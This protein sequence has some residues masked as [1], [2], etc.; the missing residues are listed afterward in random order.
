MALPQDHEAKT[1]FVRAKQFI[2]QDREHKTFA[3]PLHLDANHPDGRT[4]VPIK[5]PPAATR[6]P[7]RNAH[8]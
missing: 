3:I 1:P 8:G 4:K 5:A 2:E 6:T 7:L